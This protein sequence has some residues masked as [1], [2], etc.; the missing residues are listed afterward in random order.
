MTDLR[1]FMKKVEDLGELQVINNAQWDLEIGA[2]V[3]M[4]AAR[5]YPSAVMFDKIQGYKPGWR[6]LTLPFTTDSRTDLLFGLDPATKGIE[7]VRRLKEKLKEQYQAIPPVEVADGPVLENVHE[8]N[9]VDL[10]E[11]PTPRWCPLDGGRYIGTGNLVIQKDPDEGWVN[12]GAYRVQIHDQSTATI[13]MERGRHGDIIRRKYWSKGQACPVAVCCGQDPLLFFAAGSAIP[14][15]V[16]EYDYVGWWRKKAVEV[17][18]GPTTGLPIPAS[19]EIVLEGEM[20]PPNVESR[21]EGPF[22]EWTGYFTKARQ[23]A[24]FRVKRIM[25]RNDPIILGNIPFVGRGVRLWV[26]D[27][28]GAARVWNELDRAIPGVVGVWINLEFG[29]RGALTV[30]LKQQFGGQGKIA[31]LI[32]LGSRGYMQKFIILVD[33]DIDPSNIRDVLWAI[34]T[35]CSPADSVDIIRDFRGGELDPR[36][37][38]DQKAAENYTQSSAIISAL[39]PFHWIKDFPPAIVRDPKLEEKLKKKFEALKTE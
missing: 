31:G 32:A 33:D 23:V 14:W 22:S 4:V 11:F 21:L 9:E 1:E 37:P 26:G 3:Q 28:I 38:P 18:K 35:R 5:P 12:I 39:K 10:F 16:S 20:V 8:G 2:I 29:P 34:A 17:I 24:A 19:A 6:V 13:Y 27:L 25:H 15:G 30:S 7:I 36:M